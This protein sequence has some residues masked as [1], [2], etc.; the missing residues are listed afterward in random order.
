MR[1]KVGIAGQHAVLHQLAIVVSNDDMRLEVGDDVAVLSG[2]RLD[3]LDDIAS[4]QREAER[5]VTIMSAFARLLLGVSDSLR[6]VDVAETPA[7]DRAAAIAEAP[8]SPSPATAGAGTSAQP[9]APDAWPRSSLLQS[10]RLV[11][12]N[13][14]MEQALSLRD[15]SRL[16]GSRL[17]QICRIIEAAAGRSAIARFSGMSQTALQRLHAA[18]NSATE[19]DAP[20]GAADRMTLAEARSLVDRLLMAWVGS[21]ARHTPGLHTR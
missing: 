14:A 1:W 4:V 10:L 3:A 17:S 8:A 11:L 2:A 12:S 19:G 9:V 6:V 15:T 5:I 18:A 21:A 13:P 16:D 7:P 20:D